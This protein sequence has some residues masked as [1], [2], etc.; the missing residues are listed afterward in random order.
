MLDRD[1]YNTLLR[2]VEGGKLCKHCIIGVRHL[3]RDLAARWATRNFQKAG[4]WI[5]NV[6]DFKDFLVYVAV[7]PPRVN[8]LNPNSP[9][10]QGSSTIHRCKFV[11]N[12]KKYEEI[13]KVNIESCGAQLLLVLGLACIDM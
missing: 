12:G 5:S 7:P 1:T 13:R 3:D 2:L 8:K 9:E 10:L 11:V 4:R 6:L